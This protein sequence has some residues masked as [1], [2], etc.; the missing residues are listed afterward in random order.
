MGICTL[1]QYVRS[2]VIPLSRVEALLSK[3]EG[4]AVHLKP[5]GPSLAVVLP[6]EGYST[7]DKATGDEGDV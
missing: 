7:S 5:S 1:G 2:V 4:S 3:G 6:T